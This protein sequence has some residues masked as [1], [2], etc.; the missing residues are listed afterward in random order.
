MQVF[1]SVGR[2]PLDFRCAGLY[3]PTSLD[4]PF[5]WSL[6]IPPFHGG[7]TGS[8]P[9]GVATLPISLSRLREKAPVPSLVQFLDGEELRDHK[10]RYPLQQG[11]RLDRENSVQPW[12][13]HRPDMNDLGE[14]NGEHQ[15]QVLT[16]GTC[17]DG[18]GLER[19]ESA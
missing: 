9:V 1:L 6:R 17:E 10:Q 19:L 13:I 2:K 11:N 4:D 16:E 18:S 14:R 3:F 7:N 12:N 15:E 8:N 5:V